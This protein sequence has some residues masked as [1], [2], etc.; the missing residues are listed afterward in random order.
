MLRISLAHFYHF[1]TIA[2]RVFKQISRLYSVLQLI[3]RV[4]GRSELSAIDVRV[5][6]PKVLLS[7]A[8]NQI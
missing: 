7:K 3:K 6:L 8:V 1:I 4:T 2:N 5:M